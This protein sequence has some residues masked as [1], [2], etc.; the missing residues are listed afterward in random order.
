MN[1]Q[2]H[3]SKKNEKDGEGVYLQLDFGIDGKLLLGVDS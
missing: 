2:T 1:Q 3:E